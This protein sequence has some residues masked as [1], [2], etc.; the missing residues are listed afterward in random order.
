MEMLADV[1][2]AR[3]EHGLARDYATRASEMMSGS[4]GENSMPVATALTNR[5]MVEQRASDLNAAAK[6][7]ERAISIVRV[8]PEQSPL[9]ATIEQRYAGLL[10]SMHRSREA[11]AMLDIQRGDP[12]VRS[13]RLR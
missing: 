13:F 1:Y 9:Q 8:H 5:A 4:F 7:Y 10:K 6:D 2:S 12:Q 3:G 11:K